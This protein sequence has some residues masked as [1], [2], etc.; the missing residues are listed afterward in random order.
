MF[1]PPRFNYAQPMILGLRAL[2]ETRE[3]V[4]TIEGDYAGRLLLTEVHKKKIKRVEASYFR[5]QHT[6][7]KHTKYI[8]SNI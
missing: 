7:H 8:Q 3:L 5:N 2:D 1:H 4:K 6:T